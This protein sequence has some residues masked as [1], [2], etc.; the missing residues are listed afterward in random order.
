MEAMRR[1]FS[2]NGL[3]LRVV[4]DNG[5]QSTSYEFK[6]FMSANGIKHQLIPPYHPA[7]NGQV[8]RIVQDFKKSLKTKPTGRSV[9]HQV[10]TF[11]LHYRKTPNSTTGKTPAGLMLKRSSRTRLSLLRPEADS[12][13]REPQI[14][15]YDT[16]SGRVRQLEPG[17]TV[18]VANPRQDS[19]GK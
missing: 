6:N 19:R 17:M 3:P 14:Q 15:Q 7:S 10:S 1:T 9:S 5:P 8:E 4:T 12:E 18:S 2:Y 13:L 11:L 16:A